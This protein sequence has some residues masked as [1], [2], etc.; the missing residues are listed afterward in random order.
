MKVE[1]GICHPWEQTDRE[2]CDLTKAFIFFEKPLYELYAFRLQRDRAFFNREAF[3]FVLTGEIS[4]YLVSLGEI[5]LF[6]G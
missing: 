2:V 4:Q 1:A 6:V 5:I 3:E